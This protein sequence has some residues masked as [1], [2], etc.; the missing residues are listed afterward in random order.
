MEV[1]F[2]SFV[3]PLF[4]VKWYIVK[5]QGPRETVKW[6]SNGLYAIDTSKVWP[7]KNG[8]LV[9]LELCDQVV[10]QPMHASSSCHYVIE[11][12]PRSIRTFHQEMR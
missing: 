7:N 8:T 4:D 9:L 12:A 3:L 1:N 6:D 2:R 11:I 5:P 10:F